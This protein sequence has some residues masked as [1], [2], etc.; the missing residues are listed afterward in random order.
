M[1]P[2]ITKLGISN[3]IVCV[4]TGLAWIPG[5]DQRAAESSETKRIDCLVCKVEFR[6]QCEA[7]SIE[8]T[9]PIR[10]LN[11][12]GQASMTRR[13]KKVLLMNTKNPLQ[14][15]RKTTME[16]EL[17]TKNTMG[18]LMRKDNGYE[19]QLR[20]RLNITSQSYRRMKS[21]IISSSTIKTLK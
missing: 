8:D 15:R 16:E 3:R 7:K 20:L 10:H 19:P 2:S 14:K 5:L 4:A 18:S 12:V 11:A 6:G 17:H 9:S 21:E 13:R 1:D